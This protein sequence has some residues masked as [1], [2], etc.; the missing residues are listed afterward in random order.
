MKNELTGQ[1]LK[2][3]GAGKQKSFNPPFR[4][5]QE[6]LYTV[7]AIPS[8]SGIPSFRFTKYIKSGLVNSRPSILLTVTETIKLDVAP[9][10]QLC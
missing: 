5:I 7:S 9:A 1:G 4:S 2:M 6:N 10:V 3:G 8:S